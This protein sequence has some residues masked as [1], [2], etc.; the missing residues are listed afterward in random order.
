M[1]S[2]LES[3]SSLNAVLPSSDLKEEIFR[4]GIHNLLQSSVGK[5][6]FGFFKFLLFLQQLN[7]LNPVCNLE[8]SQKS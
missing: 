5:I 1:L 7:F 6:T 3:L 4:Q 2:V 8:I